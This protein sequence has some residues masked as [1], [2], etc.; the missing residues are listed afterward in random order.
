MVASKFLILDSASF[1][2]Q[3]GP[4]GSDS[5]D[6]DEDGGSVPLKIWRCWKKYESILQE[7]T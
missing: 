5:N 4:K 1:L 7:E 2:G 6:G 3:F